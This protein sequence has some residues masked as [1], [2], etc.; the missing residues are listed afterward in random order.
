MSIIG[1]VVEGPS[2]N[3]LKDVFEGILAWIFECTRS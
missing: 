3:K 2:Q 1:C